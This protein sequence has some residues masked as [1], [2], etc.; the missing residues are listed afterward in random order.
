[1][2]G[3][4]VLSSGNH[5]VCDPYK[6]QI[7]TED[8]EPGRPSTTIIVFYMP[9]GVNEWSGQTQSVAYACTS[10][11][12]SPAADINHQVLAKWGASKITETFHCMLAIEMMRKRGRVSLGL[13][14]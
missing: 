12:V 5:N 11:S 13:F 9:I 4:R 7:H 2:Q 10:S 6:I 3:L 1:M 8:P 14:E